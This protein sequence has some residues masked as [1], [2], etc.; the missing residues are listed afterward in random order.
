[1]IHEFSFLLIFVFN[2]ISK[3]LYY[4]LFYVF[5]SFYFL[6]C[7]LFLFKILLNPRR[8][9]TL[10]CHTVNA[11][12]AFCP[13]EFDPYNLYAITE[14]SRK[15]KYHTFKLFI[16]KHTFLYTVLPPIKSFPPIK[17]FCVSAGDGNSLNSHF[18]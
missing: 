3:S 13:C 12:I 9:I 17:I 14:V 16:S 6:F 8:T 10:T 7:F 15:P 11:F 5:F 18:C 4:L 2:T 1:V